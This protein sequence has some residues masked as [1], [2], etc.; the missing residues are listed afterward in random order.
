MYDI[1]CFTVLSA[2]GGSILPFYSTDG[3]YLFRQEGY[4][5]YLFG[6]NEDNVWGALDARN[7]GSDLALALL[8]VQHARL[9]RLS[10]PTNSG[11][12][13]AIQVGLGRGGPCSCLVHAVVKSA[14]SRLEYEVH[15]VISNKCMQLSK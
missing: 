12:V 1:A 4:F 9:S 13:A 6:I 2:Q 15:A 5:H 3:E 8:A 14:A 11:R 10:C 7:V